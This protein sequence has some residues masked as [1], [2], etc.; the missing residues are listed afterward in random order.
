MPYVNPN[1]VRTHTAQIAEITTSTGNLETSKLSASSGA[2]IQ[3]NR[4][5]ID[6]V[7]GTSLPIVASMLA[8][9]NNIVGTSLPIMA[10]MLTVQN[11][12]VGTSLP[13]ITQ[14]MQSTITL[15]AGSNITITNDGTVYTIS[16]TAADQWGTI[17][18]SIPGDAFATNG[19]SYSAPIGFGITL[20]SA[21]VTVTAD[22]KAP[23]GAGL[24]F[25]IKY[26]SPFVTGTV[27]PPAFKSIFNS[28][29]S[30]FLAAGSSST[31]SVDFLQTK[32]KPNTVFRL[33]ILSIGSATP[34]GAPSCVS[35]YGRKD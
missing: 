9:Q 13:I 23:T 17:G 32:Y 24:Y 3:A 25:D 2:Y 10:N 5:D 20:T 27:Y 7:Y 18:F 21:V 19:I 8:V 16:G 30:L 14:I 29:S 12:I 1:T 11:S 15:A 31:T 34:G 28:T 4:T 35:V 6:T 26:S 33:D 22:G